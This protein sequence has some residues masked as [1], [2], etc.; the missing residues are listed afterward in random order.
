MYLG[1]SLFY[2]LFYFSFMSFTSGVSTSVTICV[3]KAREEDKDRKR[4][5]K[6]KLQDNKKRRKRDER[7]VVLN[8]I[9]VTK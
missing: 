6:K 1:T 2:K 8:P 9:I 7:S 5:F 4:E 3:E